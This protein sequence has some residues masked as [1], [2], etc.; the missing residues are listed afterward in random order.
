[1]HHLVFFSHRNKIS[2]WIFDIWLRALKRWMS[3]EE[4]KSMKSSLESDIA[5]SS[6]YPIRSPGKV[7][8]WNCKKNTKL[9]S[10]STSDRVPL[11]LAWVRQVFNG[12]SLGRSVQRVQHLCNQNQ[13]LIAKQLGFLGIY[14]Y[15]NG[16]GFRRAHFH[17]A[18]FP[19]KFILSD[20]S[21]W[22]FGSRNH[23][24]LPNL[25]AIAQHGFVYYEVDCFWTGT[26]H[27]LSLSH[28]SNYIKMKYAS[29]KI[30]VQTLYIWLSSSSAKRAGPKGLH[31]E[32]ARAVTGRRCPHSA[33]WS[34]CQLGCSGSQNFPC[35]S[36]NSYRSILFVNS[37]NGP[38]QPKTGV[39]P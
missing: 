23:N 15:N 39:S 33:Q 12:S 1:M 5:P 22:F 20:L 17:V 31:A 28:A 24:R 36:G 19:Q 21:T 37:W 11:R 4:E 18:N 2:L 29:I 10:C 6:P 26:F 30:N 27:I 38:K 9:W 35:I 34:R 8:H 32:S 7:C 13:V 25:K 14:F 3:E 16:T